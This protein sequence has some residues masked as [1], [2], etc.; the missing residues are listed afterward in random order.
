MGYVILGF[1]SRNDAL[2]CANFLNREKIYNIVVSTPSEFKIGCGLSV[3]IKQ[4]MLPFAMD[5]IRKNGIRN[6]RGVYQMDGSGYI[7]I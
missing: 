6:L 3:K 2:K 7:K 4:S 1:I 5:I